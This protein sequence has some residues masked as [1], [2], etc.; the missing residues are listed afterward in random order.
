ML[1]TFPSENQ[2][3]I[4]C[5]TS[6]MPPKNKFNFVGRAVML[7]VACQPD[8]PQ[9]NR[10]ARSTQAL[11]QHSVLQ[12]WSANE[13]CPPKQTKRCLSD[14]LRFVAEKELSWTVWLNSQCLVETSSTEEEKKQQIKENGKG[15]RERPWKGGAWIGHPVC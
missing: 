13:H 11:A 5:K 7:Q 6:S 15:K 9:R 8:P 10:T 12:T 1:D 14:S 3:N 2:K 4:L